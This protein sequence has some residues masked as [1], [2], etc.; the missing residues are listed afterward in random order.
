MRSMD[1]RGRKLIPLRMNLFF[2][3]LKFIGFVR[4]N[5]DDGSDKAFPFQIWFPLPLA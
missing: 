5:R 3:N 2:S 1:W 4:E